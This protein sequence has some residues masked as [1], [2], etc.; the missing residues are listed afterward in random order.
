MIHICLDELQGLILDHPD[1][2]RLNQLLE[3]LDL[4]SSDTLT[5][6][7]GLE[8]LLQ[9]ALNVR[10]VLNGLAHSEAEVSEPLVV[11]SD[12]PVLAEEL[13]DVWDDALLVS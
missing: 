5:I 7:C 12:S 8:G 9:D 6:L 10:H 2:L 1:S 11:E 3:V 13:H 4:V